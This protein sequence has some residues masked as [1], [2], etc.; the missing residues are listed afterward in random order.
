MT[1][2]CTGMLARTTPVSEI[3]DLP[4]TPSVPGCGAS[5]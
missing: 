4:R 5:Q 3:S 1:M 2:K